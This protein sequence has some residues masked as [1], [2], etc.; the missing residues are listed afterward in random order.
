MSWF[1]DLEDDEVVGDL[2]G[3]LLPEERVITEDSAQCYTA[4][5]MIAVLDQDS[6]DYS[7]CDFLIS[8]PVKV[9][10]YESPDQ[11]GFAPVYLERLATAPRHLVLMADVTFDYSTPERFEIQTGGRLYAHAIGE[12]WFGIDDFDNRIDFVGRNKQVKEVVVNY[13]VLLPE[14]PTD[15]RVR[16]VGEVVL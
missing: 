8:N 2:S 15:P 11:I 7:A 4:R 13:L 12:M 16:A 10:G 5:V 14:A 3:D 1:K 9:Y 6:Y